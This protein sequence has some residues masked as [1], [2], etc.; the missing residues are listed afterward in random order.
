MWVMSLPMTVQS[1]SPY[2]QVYNDPVRYHSTLLMYLLPSCSGNSISEVESR[3]LFSSPSNP[4]HLTPCTRSK[5]KH[6]MNED[7]HIPLSMTK[8]VPFGL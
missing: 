6:W 2:D 5:V 4:T 1:A 3:L 7:M 8:A